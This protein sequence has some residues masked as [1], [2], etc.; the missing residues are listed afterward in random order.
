MAAV[1]CLRHFETTVEPDRP[2]AEWELSP[3]GEAAL[4]SSL[5]SLPP[6]ERVVTSPEP[7]AHT[8]A[9]RVA[10]RLGVSLT[11]DDALAEVDRS[12]EGFVSD[13]RYEELV[14]EYFMEPRTSVGWEDRADVEARLSGFV[15]ELDGS[16]V[17]LVSH[18]LCL[19]TLLAPVVGRD[20]FSFWSALGFGE[21]VRVERGALSARWG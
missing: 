8:S 3:A 1:H 18:G 17:L 6:V 2:V 21:I 5:D 15:S 16:R 10:E 7:K 19:T 13:E 12:E 11:V 9:R 20:R 4:A 14:R